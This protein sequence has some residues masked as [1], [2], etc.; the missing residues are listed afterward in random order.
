MRIL[1]I[2]DNVRPVVHSV[3]DNRGIRD[4]AF[5]VT[6]TL[7]KANESET[8]EQ[9]LARI[10]LILCEWAQKYHIEPSE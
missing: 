4:N 3:P 7:A 8:E 6:I 1:K 9:I 2:N 10:G 5:T